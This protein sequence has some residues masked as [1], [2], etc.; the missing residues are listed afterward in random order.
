MLNL[1]ETLVNQGISAIVLRGAMEF[2][3]PG[4]QNQALNALVWIQ[5][6]FVRTGPR[7]GKF[8]S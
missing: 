5:E 4:L 6:A 7:F 8:L 3:R 2:M 1:V